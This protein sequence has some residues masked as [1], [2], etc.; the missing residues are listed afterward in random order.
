[1]EYISSIKYKPSNRFSGIEVILVFEISLI[2]RDKNLGTKKRDSIYMLRTEL[3]R[4]LNAFESISVYSSPE[5]RISPL[6]ILI[7]ATISAVIFV[8][9]RGPFFMDTL[10][11]KNQYENAFLKL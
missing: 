9:P 11:F 8:D 10:F 5:I 3:G 6:E 7:L 1:M 4:S 2:K